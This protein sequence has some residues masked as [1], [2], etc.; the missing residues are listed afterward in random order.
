MNATNSSSVPTLTRLR[1]QASEAWT[2]LNVREQRMLL[3]GAALVTVTL[4]WLLYGWQAQ[5]RKELDVALPKATAQFARMQSEAAELA[6]LR[7]LPVPAAADLAHLVTTLQ[8]TAAGRSL[9]VT[10]RNDGNQ[11]VVSGKG[12]NFDRWTEWLADTQRSNAVRISYLDAQ[13]SA[14]GTQVEARLVPL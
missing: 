13:Q 4:L 10:V 2:G 12:L 14:D 9:V 1:R 6:R 7:S 3:I 11:L 8:T 5:Q